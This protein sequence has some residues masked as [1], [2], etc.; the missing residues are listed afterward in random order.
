M[1][2]VLAERGE[3]HNSL[4]EALEQLTADGV[5]DLAVATMC[6]MQ[7]HEMAKIEKA[8]DAWAAGRPRTV[9]IA[10]PRCLSKR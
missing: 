4:D 10:R 8:A 7:A 9:R 5:D 1:A 6:L 3:H 2:K